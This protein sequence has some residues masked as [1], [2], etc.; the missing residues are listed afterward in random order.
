MAQAPLLASFFADASRDTFYDPPTPLSSP[1]E[2]IPPF[3]AHCDVIAVAPL[4]L[5]TKSSPVRS[6]KRKASDPK[7]E[8]TQGMSQA[9]DLLNE[10]ERNLR[11][12]EATI[13]FLNSD[14]K[15]SKQPLLTYLPTSEYTTKWETYYQCPPSDMDRKSRSKVCKFFESDCRVP[16][17]AVARNATAERELN[18]FYYDQEWNQRLNP[19]RPGFIDPPEKGSLDNQPILNGKGVQ[20]REDRVKID[21]FVVAL[22]REMGSDYIDINTAKYFPRSDGQAHLFPDEKGRRSVRMKN[23]GLDVDIC[24]RNRQID[25][26]LDL[27]RFV[28]QNQGLE[29]TEE[30]EEAWDQEIVRYVDPRT[31]CSGRT[32]LSENYVS[33]S[34]ERYSPP[35]LLNEAVYAPPGGT[36]PEGLG[37]EFYWSGHD[38]RMVSVEELRVRQQENKEVDAKYEAAMPSA[39]SNGRRSNSRSPSLRNSE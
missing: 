27:V 30:E 17:S 3:Q 24:I 34:D 2:T 18:P 28:Y 14:S 9:G 33:D 36:C 26:A 13:L 15:R 12:A 1:A 8:S 29:W 39:E 35:E 38:G 6:R 4:P 19:I 20:K 16:G 25:R 32:V 31:V 7:H 23:G 5:P 10:Q 21:S 11:M 37:S 22:Q